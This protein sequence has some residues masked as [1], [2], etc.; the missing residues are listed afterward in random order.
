MLMWKNAEMCLLQDYV[1]VKIVDVDIVKHMWDGDR[2]LQ[3]FD[4]AHR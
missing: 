4:R 2:I 1:A 3:T